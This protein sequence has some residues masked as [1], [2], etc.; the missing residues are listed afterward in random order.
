MRL[1]LTTVSSAV[2]LAGCSWFGGAGSQQH[3]GQNAYGQYGTSQAQ[4]RGH[5]NKLGPCQVYHAQQAVPR[6]C[7]PTQVTIATSGGQYGNFPQQPNFSAGY[8]ANTATGGFGSHTSA[9]RTSTDYHVS[10][11]NKPRRPRLRG[12]LYLGGEKSIS[13]DLINLADN[14]ALLPSTSYNPNNFREG[15]TSGTPSGGVVTDTTY[16]SVVEQVRQGNISFEDAYSTPLNIRGGFEYIVGPKTTLFA[17]AGYVYAEGERSSAVVQAELRRIDDIETFAPETI[18]NPTT[19]V[20]TETGN[21]PSTGTSTNIGFIPNVDVARFDFEFSDLERIDLEAG[22]RHYLSP[23]LTKTTDTTI[24]PFVGGAVGAARYNS[25][26]VGVTQSQL[27]LERAFESGGTTLEFFDALPNR[28]GAV[29]D[30]VALFDSQWV[31]TGTVTAGLE[32]QATER[33]AIAFETGVKFEGGRDDVNDV[34]GD[35]NISIPFT[36]R[37]SYNF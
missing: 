35:D 24:T 5:G 3:Q 6:G 26:T 32:W 11:K 25:Q 22:A 27:F 18:T 21:F 16:T 12:Q 7:D 33:T 14:G 37:G 34:K 1:L 4:A 28:G 20:V 30:D 17:N 9:V 15:S 19:G 31:P 13:G 2:L 23:I 10:D 36:I 29:I 8:G